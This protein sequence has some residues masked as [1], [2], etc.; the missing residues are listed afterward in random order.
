MIVVEG[1]IFDE[2]QERGG[3]HL[4]EVLRESLL[5]FFRGGTLSFSFSL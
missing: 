3:G 1:S 4:R 5:E 2:D